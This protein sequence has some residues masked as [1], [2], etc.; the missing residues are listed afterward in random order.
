[1]PVLIIITI[2]L[3]TLYTMSEIKERNWKCNLMYIFL[4]LVYIVAMYF[5]SRGI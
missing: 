4:N 3:V 5:V 2:L 1:M